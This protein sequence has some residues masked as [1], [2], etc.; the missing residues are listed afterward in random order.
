MTKPRHRVGRA[1][2]DAASSTIGALPSTFL[3]DP[4]PLIGRELEA[5]QEQ[6][7]GSAGCRVDVLRRS[8]TGVRFYAAPPSNG[9]PIGWG[10]AAAVKCDHLRRGQRPSGRR[11]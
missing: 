10:I 7:R 3:S 5:I 4:T 2:H 11:G 8:R 1:A 9:S 6:L